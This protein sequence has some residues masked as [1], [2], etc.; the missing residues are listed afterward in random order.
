MIRSGILK[1]WLSLV[2]VISSTYLIGIDRSDYKRLVMNLKSSNSSLMGSWGTDTFYNYLNGNSILVSSSV[3]NTYSDIEG[4]NS[5]SYE[6][7][8]SII[9]NETGQQIDYTATIAGETEPDYTYM[10][11]LDRQSRVVQSRYFHESNPVYPSTTTREM[12]R[13]YNAAGY[14]DSVYVKHTIGTF[15]YEQYFK[16]NFVD[17]MLHNCLVYY[18]TTGEWIPQYRYTFTYA[19]NPV[20]LPECVRWDSLINQTMNPDFLYYEQSYNPKVIPAFI[21]REQKTGDV[22]YVDDSVQYTEQ[23]DGNR[24]IMSGQASTGM[25]VSTITANSAGDIIMLSSSWSDFEE[26]GGSS[27]AMYWDSVVANDDNT[28]PEV[29]PALCAYP[30]PFRGSTKIRLEN[31]SKFGSKVSIYN[32]RGQLVRQWE[33][34]WG[35]EVFWDGKDERSMAVPSGVYLIKYEADEQVRTVKV[36]RY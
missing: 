18:R 22:W 24:V 34:V 13:R 36:L 26:A 32:L 15:V 28:I 7:Q 21:M 6:I 31:S 23:L 16:R 20:V 19:A 9:E 30:N 4:Y 5:T 17:S 1:L 14:A 27:Y 12:F 25:S 8:S 10:F 29:N 2:I 35:N 33:N 3:I 11:I